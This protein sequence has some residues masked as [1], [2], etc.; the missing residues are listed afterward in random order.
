[1]EYRYKWEFA[2]NKDFIYDNGKIREIN[3]DADLTN[4][5]SCHAVIMSN[6]KVI[7]DINDPSISKSKNNSYRNFIET[8]SLTIKQKVTELIMKS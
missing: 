5:V 1:M 8:L 4:I 2:D 6:N 3:I 7:A